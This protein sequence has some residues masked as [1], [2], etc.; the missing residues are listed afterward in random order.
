LLIKEQAGG[1]LRTI[2]DACDYMTG[3]GQQRE[4]A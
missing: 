1:I 3:I 2:R 4:A